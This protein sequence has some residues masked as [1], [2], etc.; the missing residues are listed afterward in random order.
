MNQHSARYVTLYANTNA[1]A[2]IMKDADGA[3][4]IELNMVGTGATVIYKKG[5]SDS[6][7]VLV[8]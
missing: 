8:S 4:R 2:L 6:D 1:L 3:G 7:W 5:Y